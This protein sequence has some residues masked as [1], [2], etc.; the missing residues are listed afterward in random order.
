MTYYI[1]LLEGS[2]HDGYTESILGWTSSIWLANHY[3]NSALQAGCPDPIIDTV[4][5]DTFDDFCLYFYDRLN[6]TNELH[7]VQDGYNVVEQYKLIIKSSRDNVKMFITTDKEWEFMMDD[8]EWTWPILE[9]LKTYMYRTVLFALTYLNDSYKDAFMEV[10]AP[11]FKEA[12][13]ILTNIL[14][15]Y[16][17][18]ENYIDFVTVVNTFYEEK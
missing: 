7:V 15:G 14:T 17:S 8:I 10:C 16:E 6:Q 2:V 1:I 12:S 4:E 9:D 3:C 18:W 11:V 5:C 13:T